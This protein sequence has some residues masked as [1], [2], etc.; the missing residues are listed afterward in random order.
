MAVPKDLPNAEVHFLNAGHLAVGTETQEIASL[1]LS[2][3]KKYN[4]FHPH[5][6]VVT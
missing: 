6:P 4:P 5:I 2:F 3:L 1:M